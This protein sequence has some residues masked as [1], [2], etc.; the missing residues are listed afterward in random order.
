MKNTDNGASVGGADSEQQKQPRRRTESRIEHY[1]PAEAEA[2]RR[3]PP[4]NMTIA[5]AAAFLSVSPRTIRNQI[6]ARRLTVVRIGSCV[7]LRLSDLQRALE[8]FAVRAA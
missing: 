5:E 3:N 2:I 7:R 6:A 4:M 1:D 8:K